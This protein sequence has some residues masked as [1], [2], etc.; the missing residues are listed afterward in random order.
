MRDCMKSL[1]GL[2][3]CNN[4]SI[5]RRVEGLH[6]RL[7]AILRRFEGLQSFLTLWRV[8]GLHTILQPF[9]ALQIQPFKVE[10]IALQSIKG[11]NH[12]IWDC[13]KSFEGLKDWNP[14]AT[15]FQVEAFYK[16]LRGVD[17]LH[18]RSFEELQDCTQSFNPSENHK[19]NPSRSK[20][21]TRNPLKG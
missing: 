11:L 4:F 2:K 1:K 16:I 17:A 15:L 5:L 12:C 21:C 14:F 19:F 18:S 13:M 9:R 3:D 6:V 7:R 8:E 20:D 10:E